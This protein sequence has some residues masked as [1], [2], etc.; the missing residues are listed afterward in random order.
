MTNLSIAADLTG[1][2]IGKSLA[3]RYLNMCAKFRYH[4]LS[5]RDFGGFY[6]SVLSIFFCHCPRL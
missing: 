3:G 1:Q 2:K 6:I 5:I 4:Q